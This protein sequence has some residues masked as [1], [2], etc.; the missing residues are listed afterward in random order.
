MNKK[1]IFRGVGTAMVTPM[2]EDGCKL[3]GVSGIAGD[4]GGE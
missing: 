2:K 4:A 1:V 3:S